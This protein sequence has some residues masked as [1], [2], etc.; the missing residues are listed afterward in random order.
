VSLPDTLLEAGAKALDKHA[1]GWLDKAITKARDLAEHRAA[2]ID[3]LEQPTRADE[4]ERDMLDL[5][6]GALDAVEKRSPAL[7]RWGKYKAGAVLIQLAS[8]D[9]EKARL[10][11]LASGLSVEEYLR[12]SDEESARV[13]SVTRQRQKDADEVVAVLKE[14]GLGA[15]RA[16][17]PLIL[18]GL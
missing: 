15:L 16:A 2:Q 7:L 11:A 17:I 6:P 13:G 8:G 10:F 9:S 12:V 14:V 3:E 1:E 5:V 4:I 18:A